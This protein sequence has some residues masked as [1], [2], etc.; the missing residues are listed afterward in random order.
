M[1]SVRELRMGSGGGHRS[2]PSGDS[3]MASMGLGQEL[4][5]SPTSAASFLSLEEA[6]VYQL[7]R[8]PFSTSAS[9]PPQ[10]WQ[11]LAESIRR[12]LV[13]LRSAP[14]TA[15][16]NCCIR[17]W[18]DFLHVQ[19]QEVLSDNGTPGDTWI[20]AQATHTWQPPGGA[21][22]T[23]CL[24]SPGPAAC[25]QVQGLRI[26]AKSLHSFSLEWPASPLQR[27]SHWG[28][29]RP[30]P[31]LASH[32]NA[33]R[34]EGCYHRQPGP[35]RGRSLHTRSSRP[36]LLSVPQPHRMAWPAERR[37]SLREPDL[38]NGSQCGSSA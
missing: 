15:A 22:E 32:Y 18:D 11:L 16:P 24:A 7:H 9:L 31:H 5:S 6:S 4:G 29:L 37:L 36:Q 23:L 28:S 34:M 20:R 14:W 10:V 30:A 3:N 21:Q 35:T 2:R 19:T 26:Q 13:L 27:G 1:H 17:T 33:W 38:A 25:R 12:G 8:S